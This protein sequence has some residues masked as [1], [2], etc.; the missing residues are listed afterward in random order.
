[1][2]TLDAGFPMLDFPAPRVGLPVRPPR[3]AAVWLLYIGPLAREHSLYDA[4]QAVQLAHARRV[5]ARLLMAGCGPD[6]IHLRYLVQTL[7]ISDDVTFIEPVFAREKIALFRTCDALLYL[8]PVSYVP[9]V[10]RQAVEHGLRIVTLRNSAPGAGF[11][12][13]AQSILLPSSRPHAIYEAIAT[14]A[15]SPRLRP[16]ARPSPVPG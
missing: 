14:L 3:D 8:D 5:P 2:E 12:E 11:H 15:R 10:V 16:A 7:G 9:H 6:E 1:M 13:G 4:I